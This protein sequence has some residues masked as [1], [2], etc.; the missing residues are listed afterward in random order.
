MSITQGARAPINEQITQAI[1]TAQIETAWDLMRYHPDRWDYGWQHMRSAIYTEAAKLYCWAIASNNNEAKCQLEIQASA[2]KALLVTDAFMFAV[3][4]G[5]KKVVEELL[6]PQHFWR[7]HS[8]RYFRNRAAYFI[9][10]QDGFTH[11]A[12][13]YAMSHKHLETAKVLVTAGADLFHQS[14]HGV[15]PI[16]ILFNHSSSRGISFIQQITRK[17]SA[18]NKA[19]LL[20]KLRTVPEHSGIIKDKRDKIRKRLNAYLIS[21]GQEPLQKPGAHLLSQSYQPNQGPPTLVMQK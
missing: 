21:E 3:C 13:H 16:T 10:H 19:E 5:Q 18:D 2:N 1:A 7:G 20:R 8:L 9:H 12:L 14:K 11:S 17:L 6:N 4:S 15:T